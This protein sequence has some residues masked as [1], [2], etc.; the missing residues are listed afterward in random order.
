MVGNIVGSYKIIEKIGEGGMGTVFRGID[1]MLEREVA[2]KMLRPELSHQPELVERFRTE[3]VTLAKLNHPNIA[4]LHSFLRQGNDY[5]M[6]MEYVRGATL[7]GI[8]RKHGAM[9]CERAVALFCHALEGIEHAHKMGII[10][11]DI[12]PSNIMLSNEGMVKVMDFGI[13][14]VLGTDRLTQTG[15]VIGTIEY[16]PPEQI[17]RQDIDARS[18]I[19]SLG[20]L[21]YEMLT[22]RVPFSSTSEY[23][24]MRSQIEDAPMPPREFAPHIPLSIEQ[25]IMRSLAK[26][27]EARFQTAGAFRATLINA[28]GGALPALESFISDYAAPSIKPPVIEQAE[29]VV[30]KETRMA[31]DRDASPVQASNIVSGADEIKETR[32]APASNAQTAQSGIAPQPTAGQSLNALLAKLNWKHYAGAGAALFV[33]LAVP[34]V[35]MGGGSEQ[36]KT[37]RPAAINPALAPDAGQAVAPPPRLESESKPPLD[38]TS[39]EDTPGD[40]QASGSGGKQSGSRA[41]RSKPA[42]ASDAPA[43]YSAPKYNQPAPQPQAQPPQERRETASSPDNSGRSSRGQDNPSAPAKEDKSLK[44]KVAD[45]VKEG[46]KEVGKSIFRK[47]NKP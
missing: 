12:K 21:L 16:M 26:R 24:L 14:R 33:L 25:A 30:L 32:L 10:H 2:I 6:V 17:R 38:L 22:G 4:T 41:T 36:N 9:S 3:A 46:V 20:I 19:Y 7:E 23:D 13:A 34:I 43:T 47:F 11:R 45:G 39:S 29:P 5:F 18:D 1:I 37:R 35:F 42:S 28:I 44:G 27:Q 31:G 15:H 8:I 40:N